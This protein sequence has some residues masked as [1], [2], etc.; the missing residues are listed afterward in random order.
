MESEMENIIKMT[1]CEHCQVMEPRGKLFFCGVFT[2][3][4]HLVLPTAI[5]KHRPF[6][7][8]RTTA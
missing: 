8:K 5:D 7:G 6:W 4:D 2:T 3:S 1:L